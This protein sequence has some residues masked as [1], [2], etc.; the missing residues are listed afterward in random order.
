MTTD[1]LPIIL[2]TRMLTCLVSTKRGVK[3]AQD[4]VVGHCTIKY[5][6]ILVI[7]VSVY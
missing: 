3:L 7:A 4:R 1:A 5:R 6:N 2:V